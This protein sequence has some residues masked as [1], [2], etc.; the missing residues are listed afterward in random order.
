MRMM[1]NL[2][3]AAAFAA[4]A[5]VTPASAGEIP[6]TGFVSSSVGTGY[7]RLLFDYDAQGKL[8]VDPESFGKRHHFGGR[9]AMDAHAEARGATSG[10]AYRSMLPPSSLDYE[11]DFNH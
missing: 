1:N 7:S 2:A 11:P 5:V 6:A 8:H 9:S 3:T 4:F 10:P